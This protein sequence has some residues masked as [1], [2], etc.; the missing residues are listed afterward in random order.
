MMMSASSRKA[1]T[2]GLRKSPAPSRYVQQLFL[3]CFVIQT[4]SPRGRHKGKVS[5]FREIHLGC[6]LCMRSSLLQCRYTLCKT[7]H[8][9]LP[10]LCLISC[11]LPYPYSSFTQSSPLFPPPSFALRASP[12]KVFQRS[13]DYL[14]RFQS[15]YFPPQECSRA[16]RLP[17]CLRG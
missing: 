7:H 11:C 3:S 9:S 4:Y 1:V 13:R 15:A 12:C 2:S 16:C 8:F 17:C 14:R 6:E 5:S 10:S